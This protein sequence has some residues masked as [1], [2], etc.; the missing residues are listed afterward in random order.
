MTTT[1]VDESFKTL[2]CM[3]VLTALTIVSIPA[4]RAMP[5]YYSSVELN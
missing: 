3:Y 1:G 4:R 2:G 5:I